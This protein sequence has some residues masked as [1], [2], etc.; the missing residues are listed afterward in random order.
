EVVKARDMVV[1]VDHPRL[2]E[3]R[4]PGV[5]VKLQNARTGVWRHPPELGEHTDEV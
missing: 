5:P 2:G 4:L 1:S 3:L